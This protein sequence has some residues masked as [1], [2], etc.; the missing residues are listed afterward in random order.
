MLSLSEYFTWKAQCYIF[1]KLFWRL[2]LET[3]YKI[4]PQV[5]LIYLDTMKDCE[6]LES[7]EKAV[8]DLENSSNRNML[9]SCI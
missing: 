3:W 7:L 9:L 5:T 6:Q 8:K 4:G 1:L 2:L